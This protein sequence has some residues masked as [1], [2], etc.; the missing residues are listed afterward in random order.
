MADHKNELESVTASVDKTLSEFLGKYTVQPGQ[1][2]PT[3][4]HGNLV[5]QTKIPVPHN[6]VIAINE[7]EAL[8][9]RMSMIGEQRGSI[10]Q[11]EMKYA[12]YIDSRLLKSPKSVFFGPRHP[13]HFA[14]FQDWAPGKD[15]P[16]LDQATDDLL[17]MMRQDGYRPADFRKLAPL[18]V[19]GEDAAL[20][21]IPR[22][23]N[24]VQAL[25][26]KRPPVPPPPP[27]PQ[28]L[29]D[30]FG[31]VMPP[32]VDADGSLWV[33][34]SRLYVVERSIMHARAQEIDRMSNG[35]LHVSDPS[36]GIYQEPGGGSG[37]FD[38][39]LDQ[40]FGN[41]QR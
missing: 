27:L 30:K 15:V 35:N 33:G 39:D 13:W 18:F 29:W 17:G 31:M 26:A 19:T 5:D 16:R 41:I 9:R 37:R 7:T 14:F 23:R 28:H 1:D 12:N 22:G 25:A 3:D 2:D 24:I 32:I 36:R 4:K 11:L 40:M 21:A 20:L 10:L 34:R 8:E 38:V 6:F